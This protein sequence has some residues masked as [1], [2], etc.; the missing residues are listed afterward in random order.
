MG[1]ASLKPDP[2]VRE[3][4]LCAR[5][6]CTKRRKPPATTRYATLQDF[7]TDPFCSTKCCRE[8]H[9]GDE[10]PPMGLLEYVP[11]LTRRQREA[12]EEDVAARKRERKKP[13]PRSRAYD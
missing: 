3:D 7:E 4:G 12:I 9:G 13:N 5:P 6:G 8:Y 1:S 10:L 2:P 11:E